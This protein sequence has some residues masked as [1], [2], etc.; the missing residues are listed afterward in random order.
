M[1]NLDR[2]IVLCVSALTCIGEFV[3]EEGE[4]E[5]LRLGFEEGEIRRDEEEQAHP[6]TVSFVR[7]IRTEP[8]V[9]N[10]AREAL[11]L[12]WGRRPRGGAGGLRSKKTENG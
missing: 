7:L 5:E 1:G 12:H 6:A 2:Y 10:T 3:P 4:G 11:C 9:P 8:G